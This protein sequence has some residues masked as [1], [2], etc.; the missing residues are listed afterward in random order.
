MRS[1]QDIWK[2]EEAGQLV[3]LENLSRE[4]GILARGIGSPSSVTQPGNSCADPR[5]RQIAPELS[6]WQSNTN[7]P[8]KR[9]AR[10]SGSVRC[11]PSLS[12]VTLAET[13]WR[14]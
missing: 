9:Q 14:K 7:A 6:R 4:Q 11:F 3:I 5:E 10:N 8:P 2:C 13:A 12:P 1:D